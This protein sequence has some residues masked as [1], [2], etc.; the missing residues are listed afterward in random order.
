M[1]GF[2]KFIPWLAYLPILIIGLMLIIP[3]RVRR[4]RVW[5]RFWLFFTPVWL[6]TFIGM[7]IG[8]VIASD[9]KSRPSIAEVCHQAEQDGLGSPIIA[10]GIIG[11]V[12][13]IF[14]LTAI[15]K[16]KA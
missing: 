13:A 5:A 11:L 2:V 16:R 10:G 14:L 6:F 1:C 7:A 8:G 4:D 12:L 15:R 3:R 9:F